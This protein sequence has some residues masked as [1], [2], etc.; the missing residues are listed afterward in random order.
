MQSVTRQFVGRSAHCAGLRSGP[1]GC[2]A[3]SDRLCSVFQAI[4]SAIGG[5][6]Y[7][8][9]KVNQWT[10][11]VVEQTLSQLTKLGKPFKYIGKAPLL[12]V[13][14]G[15][16]SL[17]TA[18]RESVR[19]D[20]RGGSRRSMSPACAH[21]GPRGCGNNCGP[22][23]RTSQHFRSAAFRVSAWWGVSFLGPGTLPLQSFSFWTSAM[24]SNTRMRTERNVLSSRF[25]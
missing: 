7:Q 17:S 19:G 3:N 2:C 12:L 15:G 18:E 6:A 14:G 9:S 24:W 21:P 20:S 10:T 5:N 16:G 8:H 25:L 4:E 22:R 11:N 13:D 23:P 1:K